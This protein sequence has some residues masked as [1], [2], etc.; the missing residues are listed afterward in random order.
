MATIQDF[1]PLVG[2][3]VRIRAAKSASSRTKNRIREH[4]GSTTGLKVDKVAA[5]DTPSI[6]GRDAVLFDSIDTDWWGWLPVEEI[7]LV[8]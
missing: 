5:I 1:Q 8:P 6:K 4:S 7:E 2:Q 3:T